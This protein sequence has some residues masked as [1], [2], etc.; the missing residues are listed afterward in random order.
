MV[1]CPGPVPCPV[2]GLDYHK[3]MFVVPRSSAWLGPPVQDQGYADFRER[4]Y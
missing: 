3:Q 2:P 1:R 4:P